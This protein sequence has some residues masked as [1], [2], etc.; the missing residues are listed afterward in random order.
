V[1]TPRFLVLCAVTGICQLLGNVALIQAFRRSN[2]AQSIV[3]HK[4]EVVFTAVIG[5][6]LFGEVPS[7]LGW[8]GILGCGVGVVAMNLGRTGGGLRDAFRFDTGSL[9]AFQCAL[10]LVFASFALK[11]ATFEFAGSNPTIGDG[12]FEPAAYTLFHTTWIEV[13]ILTVWIRWRSPG[14]FAHVP[15]HLGRMALIGAT[16][17]LGSLGWFWA[18]S[19]TLVAYVKAVGQI[20]ALLA[21]VL[22]LGVWRER[23]VLRQIPGV[24]LIV[25]GIALV[26]LGGVASNAPPIR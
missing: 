6:A 8:L 4:L 7:S 22:A 18:Y 12:R 3:L 19:L 21:V 2:F 16:G 1:H 13:V 24:L 25:L 20:E 15:R 10:L 11:Q 5:A 17:F 26:L 9:L 14:E 23:E